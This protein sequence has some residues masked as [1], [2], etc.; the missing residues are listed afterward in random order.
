MEKSIS[1]SAEPVDI[2]LF[3]EDGVTVV[4]RY[5]IEDIFSEEGEALLSALLQSPVPHP[6]IGEA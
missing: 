6:F 2:T 1:A 4:G 5:H 3:A